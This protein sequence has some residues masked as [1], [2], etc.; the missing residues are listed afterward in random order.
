M[1]KTELNFSAM[2]IGYIILKELDKQNEDYVSI[3][4]VYDALKREGIFNSRQLIIGLAFLYCVDV[5]EFEEANIWIK[6]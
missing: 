3:F 2:Y 6:R 1:S 4:D 5:I